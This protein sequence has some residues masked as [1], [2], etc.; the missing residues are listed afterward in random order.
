VPNRTAAALLSL[1]LAQAHGG[2]SKWH[3]AHQPSISQASSVPSH[4]SPGDYCAHPV[5]QCCSKKHW[6]IRQQSELSSFVDLLFATGCSKDPIFPF[7]VLLSDLNPFPSTSPSEQ[8]PTMW[9]ERAE[10][11]FALPRWALHYF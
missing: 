4:V 8:P 1:H 2:Q 3:W 10:Q 9:L 11:C 5:G 7:H 6:S